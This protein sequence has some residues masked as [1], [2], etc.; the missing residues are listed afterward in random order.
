[1][2]VV[3]AEDSL[4]GPCWL[5]LMARDLSAAERFYGAVLGWTFRRGGFGRAFCVAEVDGV[6]VAGI[7]AMAGELAV[8]VAWTVYFSVADA[9]V[10]VARTRERGGTV[11][12]GPVS[13]PPR[14]R[15][16]LVSDPEGASFG[17]RSPPRC[18]GR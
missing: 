18:S 7:G 10:A 9:D 2:A 8:P 14:G 5:S 3:M 4:G 17:S 16:A 13:F 11:G 15:A 1:M 6:A 12:V